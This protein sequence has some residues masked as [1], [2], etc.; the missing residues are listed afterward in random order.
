MRCFILPKFRAGKTIVA[1]PVL[2]A[3]MM[4]SQ[5]AS[6]STQRIEATYDFVWKGMLVSTAETVAQLDEEAY[7]LDVEMRMRGLAKLFVGGGKTTF[8]A[9]GFVGA[10]GSIQPQEYKSS[11]KWR[12][13]RYRESLR[14]DSTGKFIGFEK[15]WPE[16]WRAQNRRAPVPAALQSGHDPASVLLALMRQPIPVVSAESNE[17]S[18]VYKVFDGDTVI[19]WSMTCAVT[20]VIMD[21]T[22]YSDTL[23]KAHECQLHQTL[24]AGQRILTEKQKAKKARRLKK[25]RKKQKGNVDDGPLIV[26]MQAIEN[27]SYWLPVRASVPS[28]KGI[29]KVYLT[30]L[31]T[32]GLAE[33][34]NTYITGSR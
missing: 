15:D 26:W 19:D 1:G 8:S 16:K 22:K 4:I 12:G 28:E 27:G 30:A 3:T 6:A 21:E 20:P 10:D 25:K 5:V 24:V 29:V 23:G 17:G 13:N 2:L 9:R 11:G 7:S 14:Y 34:K 31:E 18:A 33:G 32:E